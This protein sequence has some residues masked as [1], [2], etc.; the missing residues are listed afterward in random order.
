MT[1]KSQII[2]IQIDNDQIIF[3]TVAML[4]GE[5]D[6]SSRILS[7]D[8]AVSAIESI[9]KKLQKVIDSVKPQKSTVKFGVKL[10]VEAGKLSV[11]LVDGKG[12]ATIKIILQWSI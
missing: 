1:A 5:E 10:S 4:G 11:F 2:P 9:A 6:V 12:E 3:A 7:F 8:S